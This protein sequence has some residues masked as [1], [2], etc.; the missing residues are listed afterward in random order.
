MVDCGWWRW[1]QAEREEHAFEPCVTAVTKTTDCAFL[2][3][4]SLYTLFIDAFLNN[5]KIYVTTTTAAATAQAHFRLHN[6]VLI[7]V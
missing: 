7:S 4:L 6:T 5:I 2:Y 3:S 1:E